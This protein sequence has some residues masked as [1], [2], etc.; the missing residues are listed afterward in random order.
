MEKFKT[1]FPES[2]PIIGMIH[3]DSL[4]GTPNYKGDNKKIIQKALNEA[5]IYYD[6]DVNAVMI[7]NMHD[8]PYLKQSV[9]HEI[10]AIMSVIANEI[11]E[12]TGLICGIQI[13]AGAN[14]E[15]LAVAHAAGLEFIRV[16]GYVFGHIGDEGYLDSCAGKL[17]R[18]RKQIGAEHI[19]IFT[20]VKK[21]HS[22]H[23]ITAD[24][25]IVETAKAAQFFLSDGII[26]TGI[27]TGKE[28][29]ISEIIAVKKDV[30]LPVLIGSGITAE[31]IE[32]YINIADGFIVGSYLKREGIWQNE[33]NKKRVIT[34]I[35]TI[36]DLKNG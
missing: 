35:D 3:L 15:A 36:N 28:A 20:D 5:M 9:G 10:T 4:P 13:L 24:I 23:A 11:K 8:V 17:L 1:L 31:N 26:L 30:E 27:A 25:D 33:V 16:E 7:E 6:C 29:D 2:K 32:N 18:Y 12:K 22:S 14:I 19:L 21:K 34:L